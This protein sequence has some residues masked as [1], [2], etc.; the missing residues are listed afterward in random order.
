MPH[1]PRLPR[2]FRSI[3]TGALATATLA[4]A[5]V[6]E[7]ASAAQAG[8]QLHVL[9]GGVDAAEMELQLDQA[10]AANAKVIRVDVG[11]SSLEGAGKGEWSDYHLGR[12]D[13]VVDGA[14]ERGIKPLLT[15]AESPC[16]ASSAPASLKDGCSGRP[17]L[18]GVTKY[19][20]TDASDYGDALAFVAKRYGTRVAGWEMWNEPNLEFFNH[21]ENKAERYAAFVKAAYAKAKPAA[22]AVT[23]VAGA[24]SESDASFT[25]DL[26]DAG[27]G[28]SFDAFSIH[29]Y[30]H[31]VSP[32]EARESGYRDASFIRGVPAVREVLLDHGQDKPIWLTEFGWSTNT[33]RNAKPWTNGVDEAVQAQ[34]I[35]DA[36]AQASRWSYVPVAIYYG[37]KDNGDDETSRYDTYGLTRYDGSPK[38]GLAAFRAAAG[39]AGGGTVPSRPTVVG[40]PSPSLHLSLPGKKSDASLAPGTRTTTTTT[41]PTTSPTTS[42]TTT[43]TQPAPATPAAESG[44]S[45]AAGGSA[46]P[47]EG[48]SSGLAV[49][50]GPKAKVRAEGRAPGARQ[51]VLEVRRAR[52]GK[53]SRKAALRLRVAV[54]SGRFSTTFS[55]RRLARGTYRVGIAKGR[56]LGASSLLTVR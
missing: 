32:T 38:P 31:D 44:T 51:V 37:L 42:P 46:T 40:D 54:K 11:W 15:L 52:G 30:S 47:V 8:M 5:A 39:G 26:L 24:L 50:R 16:W 7:P 28:G 10:A 9:W 45:A 34:Y 2:R 48:T 55:V 53:A 49:K 19:L 27:I 25:E 35:R 12:L 14:A 33:T 56:T 4:G 43:P 23:F 1:L 21:G 22:P 6:A 29:P 17:D 20:P 3:L 36:L 13:A 41:T 18:R